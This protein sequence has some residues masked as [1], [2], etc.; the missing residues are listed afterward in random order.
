MWYLILIMLLIF[1]IVQIWYSLYEFKSD[2]MGQK[3][4]KT[5]F[6]YARLL[7][8]FLFSTWLILFVSLGIVG[9]THF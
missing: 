2:S 8:L 1:L 4:I 9:G 5:I 7:F 6:F 3:G